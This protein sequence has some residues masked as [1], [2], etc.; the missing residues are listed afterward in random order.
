MRLTV[1][2]DRSYILY[3]NVL[4]TCLEGTCTS[5]VAYRLV[6]LLSTHMLYIYIVY[7]YGGMYGFR[8]DDNIVYIICMTYKYMIYMGIIDRS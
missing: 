7:V 6:L 8:E 4:Y 2:Y 5:H 1:S 3:N